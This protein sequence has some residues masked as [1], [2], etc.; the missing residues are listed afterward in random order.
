MRLGA[1]YDF[2][3]FRLDT[4]EHMLLCRGSV[5]RLTLKAFAVL[6]I[7]VENAGHLVEKEELMKLCWPDTFVEEANVAENISLVRRAL[8]ESRHRCDYIQTVHRRGYRFIAAVSVQNGN[9]DIGRENAPR[10]SQRPDGTSDS[11]TLQLDLTYSSRNLRHDAERDQA[12]H[13]YM[14]GR[15]YWSKYTVDG[16]HKGISFF[17][18][19]IKI[20]PDYAPPYAG[21]ADCY[22]RLANIHLAPRHSIP[23]ARAAVLK[24]I[25][26]D[27]TAVEAHSLLGLIRMFYDRD[28][29]A[30]ETA[31]GRAIDLA[32]E[33]PLAHKR[34]GWA[35]GM[36]GR[37]DE[38]IKE[39]NTALDLQPHSSDIRVGL[40]IV[41]YLA[42][43]YDEAIEQAQLSLDLRP[44]FFPAHVLLGIAYA[45]QSRPTRAIAELQRGASLADIPWVLG[46]LGYVYGISG[47]RRQA[48][49]V[50]TEL[51]KRAGQDYVSP[52]A[53]A[54]VHTGLG[55]K[56]LA[57]DALQE[58]YEDRNEMLGFIWTSP[59]LDSLRSEQRFVALMRRSRL[60]HH[61]HDGG[62]SNQFQV[63]LEDH[64]ATSLIAREERNL[65]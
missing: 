37:F 20:D 34:Y 29:P 1:V 13:L 56:E 35:L 6:R 54:L 36:L 46:Y 8:G 3:H 5:V 61:K 12:H 7:L 51:E 11:E 21:L 22:Y 23:K 18:H 44:E 4:A 47:R 64:I 27:E 45:Q 39:I 58:T 32:P 60:E 16:L 19:A 26:L 31:F 15:Y 28:W 65:H 55:Q 53:I 25:H 43:R 49:R 40:G 42:R 52:F 9:G 17:R 24:A 59:E 62:G 41:L 14:R 57:L 63:P 2:G 38:G 48:S 50:L 30:A 33:S 10:D